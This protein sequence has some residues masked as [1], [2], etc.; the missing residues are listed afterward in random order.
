VFCDEPGSPASL[1]AAFESLTSVI[2]D[3]Q[4]RAL[5]GIGEAARRSYRETGSRRSQ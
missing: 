2:T 5:P 4:V 3:G 1:L